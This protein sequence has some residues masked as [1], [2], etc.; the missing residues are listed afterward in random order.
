LL[1]G[2]KDFLSFP[3]REGSHETGC[4]SEKLGDRTVIGSLTL[5]GV[6]GVFDDSKGKAGGARKERREGGG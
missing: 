2:D 4:L 3:K 6:D 1:Q 5:F